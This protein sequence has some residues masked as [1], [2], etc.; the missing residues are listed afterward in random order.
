MKFLNAW[1]RG[2]RD[3]CGQPYQKPIILNLK[4]GIKSRVFEVKKCSC[5]GSTKASTDRKYGTWITTRPPGLRILNASSR[6]FGTFVTCSSDWLKKT[7]SK[8]S[9]S[10]GQ[11]ILFASCTISTPAT[12][13]ISIPVAPGN[14][15]GPQPTSRAPAPA[16]ISSRTNPLGVKILVAQKFIILS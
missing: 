5:V 12:F 8:E 15:L 7:K 16:R 14:F 9:A 13:R 4:S 2:F 3:W 11:G 1:R 6:V 10:T